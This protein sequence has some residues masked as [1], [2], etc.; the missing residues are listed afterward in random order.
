MTFISTDMNKR[1]KNLQPQLTEYKNRPR[2]I[3]L[4]IQFRDRNVVGLTMFMGY[5][6]S[7]L[8]NIKRINTCPSLQDKRSVHR[9]EGGIWVKGY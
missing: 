9:S 4:E 2:H 5:K 8:D 1:K 6:L 7:S 3:T